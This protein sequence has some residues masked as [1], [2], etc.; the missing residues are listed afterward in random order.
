MELPADCSIFL[1]TPPNAPASTAQYRF[2]L[3]H[4]A[5]RIGNGPSL[6]RT[7]LRYPIKGGVMVVGMGDYQNGANSE[8]IVRQIERECSTRGFTGV[9]L[10]LEGP[11]LPIFQKMIEELVSLFCSQNRTLYLTPQYAI[12]S[13]SVS[14]VISTAISGGSLRQ[15]LLD[16]AKQFGAE[17]IALGLE[18]SAVDFT[19][20]AISGTGKDLTW[21]EL[22][23]LREQY[24]PTSYFSDELCAHYFTFM[25]TGSDAHFILFD[26]AATIQKKLHIASSLGI[27]QAFLPLP[28]NLILLE[29]LLRTK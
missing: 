24:G 18:W 14:V 4:L 7:D 9:F 12:S 15:H 17:Q 19:L 10:D 8:G 11:P 21:A 16:A 20:P 27:R 25:K 6:F 23:A 13:P 5:Y 28:E 29:E 2:P 22:N 26:D 1:M 3:A